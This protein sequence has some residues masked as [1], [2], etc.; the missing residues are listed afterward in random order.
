VECYKSRQYN[1]G[2]LGPERNFSWFFL[3]REKGEDKE[4]Y[5]EC[6]KRRSEAEAAP[7]FLWESKIGNVMM[8]KGGGKETGGTLAAGT[9]TNKNLGNRPNCTG[10]MESIEKK[11]EGVRELGGTLGP[12]PSSGKCQ[13]L[14]KKLSGFSRTRKRGD[15][16]WREG[17]SW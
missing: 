9:N 1:L 11:N 5:H 4:K 6:A 2:G 12:H 7:P 3:F 16:W 8:G 17:A 13:C 10:G 15:K 14:G